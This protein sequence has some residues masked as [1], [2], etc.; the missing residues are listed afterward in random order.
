MRVICNKIVHLV[1]VE[2][3]VLLQLLRKSENDEKESRATHLTCD[4]DLRCIVENTKGVVK[5]AIWTAE[6]R[7][8]TIGNREDAAS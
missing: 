5:G 4:G 8:V 2:N 1:V 3:T 6:S 7:G